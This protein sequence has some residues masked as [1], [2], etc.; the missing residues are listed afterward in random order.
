MSQWN[1]SY[2][3]NQDYQGSNTWNGELG[4]QYSNQQYYPTA[5]PT[6]EQPNQYVNFQEFLSQMQ[7]GNAAASNSA[8]YSNTQYQNYPSNQY[9]YQNMPSTSQN[10]AQSPY[11]PTSTAVNGTDFQTS[12]TQMNTVSEPSYSNQMVFKSN[13]TATA[14]EFVPKGTPKQPS[15]PEDSSIYNGL[16]ENKDHTAGNWREKSSQPSSSRSFNEPRNDQESKRK[17]EKDRRR[18]NEGRNNNLSSQNEPNSQYNE[19]NSQIDPDGGEYESNTYSYDSNKHSA[20]CSTSRKKESN[21]NSRKNESSRNYESSQNYDSNSCNNEASS[22]NNDLDRNYGSQDRIHSNRNTDSDQRQFESSSRNYDGNNRN[23]D[24]KKRYEYNNRNYDSSIRERDGGSRNYES[25]S[26]NYDSNNRS[27]DSNR[28]ADSGRSDYNR[29]DFNGRDSDYNSRNNDSNQDR[30]YGR[31]QDYNSR[32]YGRGYD[33]RYDRGNKKSKSKDVDNRTYYNSTAKSSQ[34]VR[35]G[36]AERGEASGRSRN[37]P[38][39]QRVRPVERVD[40]EQFAKGYLDNREDRY[41]K[42][43]RS[44]TNFSPMRNRNKQMDHGGNADLTQRERLSEQLDKGTLECLVCCERVKQ[45]DPVWSCGNCY[46]VLHLRCIRKWAMSSIIEGKWR[47]PACQNTSSEL[48]SEYRCMCGAVR[49]PD[50]QRGQHGAHTCGQTCQRPRSC[51]H[52]CTLPCHPGP[53]PPC[54]ATVSKQCGCGAETRSVLCSSK[55]PQVCG[56]VCSRKLEC[57]VHSCEKECHEGPCDACGASVDQVCHCPAAKTRSVPCCAATGSSQTWSCGAACAR[58]LACGAHV[59]RAPC[60]APPCEPCALMPASVLTCPCGRTKLPKDKRKSCTDAIPLCGNICAKPLP[61]GP[62]G[63]KHFCK[64]ECHE[65]ACPVCPDK[66]LLPCRCGHSSREVPCSELPQMLD[67]VFCQ[68]KCNKK[69]SCGRHRCRACCCAAAAH[70]CGVVCGRALACQLHRCEQFCHTGHC[71]PCARASFEELS[72]ECGAEVILPPVPCGAKRPACSAPCR[73]PRDC[74][75]PALHAC[76]SGPCPPCVVLTAKRC[77]GQHEVRPVPCGMRP[78]CSTPCRRPRDCGHPAL[79]A[80]HSGPCPPCVVL[81]AKRCHGQH[82]VRPVPCGMRPA[83][84]TPCRRPRDCGH[85]ALHACHSGPCP[86][87][88]VL[89]AKR[90]HG[91]HEV[92]PV[93]CG[94]RPACSAPCRRP[95]D[96]GHPALHACHSGPCPPCVVLTAKR[97]HGQHEVRPV[98]CGMRPACSTPC[99]RP[100]DCGHPALHACHSGPCPPCVVLTA[101]RCHGQHEVRP[102]P[103]GMRPACSTP[104]R[105]PRD[106]GHPALHACH[107]GPCPPCVVLTA[108]RCHGQ[109]EERKTIP[110][111]Q[112][113]FSCGLP[114]GKPLPCGKHTCQKTCHKGP[115]DAGKC[116]Q[117]CNE[118]RPSCGHPC[119]AP[120]HSADSDK[121]DKPDKDKGDKPDKPACPSSAPCRK[122]VRATC[123]CGRRTAERSCHD[124]ARDLAKIMSALAASKMQEGGS[125]DLS[126]VQRPAAMLKTL[127]CDDECRVE[128]RT[129]RLAL[130]LQIRNPDVSAKLQP[131]YS[132]HVRALAA[133]EPAFA[134]QVHD[135]LTELVQLAKK[136]K[137]KTRAH[138]FPSCNWQKRQFIHEMCEQFGCESVAYD[139]EPNR[140]VVATAD[141]EK[142]WLPAMSVLEVLARETGRRRVPGPVLRAPAATA[143]ATTTTAA[144]NKSGSG[145]A[146]LTSGSAWAARARP[147]G[148]QAARP[149]IDYFDNPPDD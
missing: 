34:D 138:S 82:E 57:G 96:C 108:K 99:R 52:P 33:S 146:T 111:S 54:Q 127:E 16:S 11:Y 129:R 10:H 119:A 1:N 38:G 66:T 80:C 63:D 70:R 64:L 130:A 143:A 106:C 45:I 117:P 71:P 102:V 47:C 147:A 131:R 32:D 24:S 68:K 21:K 42:G 55:L 62:E 123:P 135:K 48:P 77:H 112:E 79:H 18:R 60:H 5:Q 145:W 142:S 84:S 19:P 115:C 105:R 89:T 125:V 2:P 9:E 23:Y 122:L 134:R 87:C 113:E 86:P 97:C 104:C 73:R 148:P 28:G 103:C 94:M 35:S 8:S 44:E 31:N 116:T 51:P 76:H 118:K 58:V 41:A 67:N 109:H 93:P 141:K 37:W 144:A 92:R 98:P 13:L 30:E 110:C 126:E 49:S 139:A 128:A 121:A 36:R 140:N 78:A 91:Q 43:S 88:V 39:S 72:C 136:S 137:Q 81:T 74:G 14:T 27:Q 17:S 29:R 20:E 12:H 3:Y 69:L 83:C 50:Y 107:S 95:R 124:N 56:R 25:N 46:H 85:P 100:R 65:G 53:C 59:C 133:R 149:K 7:G 90:C 132:D 75:H 15:P 120:C 26:R 61:C 22:L 114:C 40:D 4:N 6:Y 101:K